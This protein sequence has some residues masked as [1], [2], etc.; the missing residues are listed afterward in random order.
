MD[1]NQSKVLETGAIL[2]DALPG[3]LLENRSKAEVVHMLIDLIDALDEI[4]YT[5]SGMPLFD[6]LQGNSLAQRKGVILRVE[7]K[8]HLTKRE[9]HILRYLANDRNPTYISNALG[10]SKST[11]KAHKY[12]IF[13]KLDIHTSE[14]LRQLL[15]KYD[16]AQPRTETSEES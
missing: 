15:S 12:S 7:K 4:E 3:Y 13:K 2:Y 1:E 16:N 11:A 10:I 9:G 6:V 8:Y 14:E 5:R